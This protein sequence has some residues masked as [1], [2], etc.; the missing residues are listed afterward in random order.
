MA[1]TPTDPTWPRLQPHLKASLTARPAP[2][3]THSPLCLLP[4]RQALPEPPLAL[5]LPPVHLPAQRAF[6]VHLA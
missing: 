6:K 2:S 4:D 3:F 5:P 1:S